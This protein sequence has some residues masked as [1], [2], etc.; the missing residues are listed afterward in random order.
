M[1]GGNKFKSRV[2]KHILG[3]RLSCPTR[4]CE[5]SP[6]SI[7]VPLRKKDD[8]KSCKKKQILKLIWQVLKILLFVACSTFFLRQSMEFYNRFYEYPTTTSMEVIN[9]EYYKMPAVTICF[10]SLIKRSKFCA[11]NPDRCEKPRQI[12]L[13]CKNH[14]EICKKNESEIK[15]PMNGYHTIP[16][17]Y[18]VCKTKEAMQKM[19]FDGIQ[20]NSLPNG[21]P[22][23]KWKTTYVYDYDQHHYARCYSDNLHI[24][25]KQK[26]YEMNLDDNAKRQQ[27]YTFGQQTPLSI[28]GIH[29]FVIEM[30]KEDLFYLR[31]QNQAFISLHSPYV[32]VN[33]FI[34]GKPMKLGHQYNIY[35]RMDEERLLP[36]PYPTNCTD[37]LSLWEKNNRTGPRSKEMCQEIC[38][39]M[40]LPSYCEI[41]QTMYRNP[42]EICN[43]MGCGNQRFLQEQDKEFLRN[44]MNDCKPNCLNVIRVNIFL[45]D[46]DVI[47]IS[48]NPLYGPWDLFSSIGGLMGCWLGISVW[49]LVGIITKTYTKFICWRRKIWLQINHRLK[50]DH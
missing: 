39:K 22:W 8:E 10:K 24:L 18:L 21:D 40:S 44:C 35:I 30:D 38:V 5:D 33:P 37:Y 34:L 19:L 41:Q 9:P 47:V 28:V 4:S 3:N 43:T 14:P 50:P 25:S 17:P 46:L 27:R 36:H 31:I 11:E 20:N 29:S 16:S 1:I 42:K 7:E 32:P 12:E 49:T 15:I 6:S 48:H 23:Q 26:A 2:G 13:F 45:S